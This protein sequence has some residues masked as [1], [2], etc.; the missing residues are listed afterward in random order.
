M[1]T[2]T[3]HII[4]INIVSNP[5]PKQWG[6]GYLLLDLKEIIIFCIRKKLDVIIYNVNQLCQVYNW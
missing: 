5:C 1:S 4:V 2:V 6:G 3:M